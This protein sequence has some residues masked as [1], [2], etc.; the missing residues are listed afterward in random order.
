[1]IHARTRVAI[2]DDHHL[3]RDGLALL[4][5]ADTRVE[6]VGQASTSDGALGIVTEA[7]PTVLLLDVEMDHVPTEVTL[8]KLRR[9]APGVRVVILTMHEDPVLER[10]LRTAGAADYVTKD[11]S[12]AF[13]VERITAVTRDAVETTDDPSPGPRPGILTDREQQVLRMIGQAHSNR[14]IGEALFIAE[15]TVKRHVLHIFA[16]L[17]ATSRLD[18]VR[19]GRLLGEV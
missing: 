14:A 5:R 1:M 10:Q 7:S 13:L 19:K 11:A 6:V 18:A 3:F 15:G 4:L 17:G 2:A 9:L 16:K 12:A 8:R